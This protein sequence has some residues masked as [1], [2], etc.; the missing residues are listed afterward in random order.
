MRAEVDDDFARWVAARQRSLVRAA[1]LVCGD[2][3]LAQD[4]V[5]DALVK[6]AGRWSR[7][8]DQNP[9]AY[10]RRIVYHD[11]ISAWRKVRRER[12]VALVPEPAPAP[13]RGFEASSDDRIALEQLLGDLTVKQRAVIVL[14]YFEDRTEADC[15]DI[16]GVS[17]GTIKS[18]AH[19]ALARLREKAGDLP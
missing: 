10:A 7:L 1:Y 14:R 16:L 11:A 17:I 5:Q 12:T 4:L 2:A 15:A 13:G 3:D 6:V 19:V 18:Q 9:D 8:R